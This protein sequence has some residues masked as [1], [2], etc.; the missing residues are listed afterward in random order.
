MLLVTGARH[1]LA[2]LEELVD[3][4]RR[5]VQRD[6]AGRRHVRAA[7][8]DDLR[9]LDPFVL[10]PPIV[11]TGGQERLDV[12]RGP[13]QR[14]LSS[15]LDLRAARIDDLRDLNPLILKQRILPAFVQE[16]L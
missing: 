1:V 16:V 13:V 2:D 10:E 11:L 6:P 8:A 4:V 3:V 5:T 15:L 12:S 14:G 9:D 7:R